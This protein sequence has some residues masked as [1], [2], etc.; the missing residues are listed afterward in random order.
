[1]S[2]EPLVFRCGACGRINRVA[3]ARL[4]AGPTCGACQQPLPT[5]GAPV[6]LDDDA[7]QRLVSKSPVPVLVDFYADWCA[8]CRLLAPTLEQ[9]GKLR[10]GRLFV[11]KVDTERHQR[12][13]ASLGVRGIP[14]IYLYR[15]G[16]VVAQRTGVQPLSELER[17]V[18]GAAAA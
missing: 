7:L 9:L 14:A 1:M 5:D 2:R 8:P 13:A 10:A 11:V 17:L 3:P 4:Q 18:S 12:T 6:H 15:D 16:R